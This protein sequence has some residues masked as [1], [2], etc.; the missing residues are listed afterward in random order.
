MQPAKILDRVKPSSR[1]IFICLCSN[2]K[3]GLQRDQLEP[4]HSAAY[5]IAV[6]LGLPAESRKHMHTMLNSMQLGLQLFTFSCAQCVQ[7]IWN[8]RNM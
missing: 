1:Q 7:A 6:L 2:A 8:I 3:G 5:S 4:L